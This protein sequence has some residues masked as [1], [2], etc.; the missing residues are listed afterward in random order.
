MKSEQIVDTDVIIIG[1]GAAG[2]SSAYILSHHNV[3]IIVLEARDRIGGR[4]HDI[5]LPKF[6]KIPLGAA[7]LHYKGETHILKPLLDEFNIKY[8]EKDGLENTTIDIYDSKGNLI[9]EKIN[10]EYKRFLSDLPKLLYHTKTRSKNIRDSIKTIVKDYDIPDE[11]IEGLINRGIE[12]CSMNADVMPTSAYDGWEPNGQLVK[13][14][15]SSF[16]TK[17]SKGI[18]N[19]LLNKVVLSVNKT[20][21]GVIVKTKDGSVYSCKYLIS[22]LPTGVLQSNL[23]KFTPNLPKIKLNAIANLYSGSHEKIFLHFPKV[24]WDRDVYAF[25]YSSDKHR[26]LCSQWYNA[27]LPVTGKKVLYTNLSGPDITYIK[28]TDEQLKDIAMDILKKIFGKDIPSPDGIY[29]TRWKNDPFTR[30]AAYAHPNM[31][32][33]MKCLDIIGKPFGRIHFAGV[34]TSSQETETVEAAILS[35][36]RASNQVLNKMK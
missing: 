18:N 3:R 20:N 14:G 29:V 25:H 28:K 31:K 11:L 9:S 7:W 12:H 36:I 2:I 26:G 13:D 22:T 23:V 15:Y 33:S 1:A 4:C 6:G 27:T 8:M 35:G 19:I 24:F 5:V 34:D 32:G 17:L 10:K 21:K 16:L 30:G